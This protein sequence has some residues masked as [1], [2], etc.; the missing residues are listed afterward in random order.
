[1]HNDSERLLA[2]AYKFNYVNVSERTMQ[3]Q[4]QLSCI[5]FDNSSS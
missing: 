1:M 2:R 5:G 3:M 4:M